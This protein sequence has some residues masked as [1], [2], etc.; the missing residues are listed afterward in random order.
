MESWPWKWGKHSARI[1]SFL[2]SLPFFL[3]GKRNDASFLRWLKVLSRNEYGRAA[4]GSALS[5]DVVIFQPEGSFYECD[6][7]H[8]LTSILSLPT[9]CQ[10]L[11]K[12]VV[13]LNGTFPE[14][15]DS[16][17]ILISSFL[18]ECR[19]VALRDRWSAEYYKAD[20][21]PDLAFSYRPQIPNSGRA[22][23]R[24]NSV[25][26]TTGA[27]FSK[28]RNMEL[29]RV[30]LD[31]CRKEDLQPL[32]L[33]KLGFHVEGLRSEIESMNGRLILRSNLSDA[34]TLVDQC[35]L[36]IGGRYHMAI[37]ALTLSI[38][39][40]L[41]RTNTHKN[42]WLSSEITG[43]ELAQTEAQIPK[44]GKRLLNQSH[45]FK[46][47]IS[48]DL[49]RMRSAIAIN[50]PH[51]RAQLR[52]D[53]TEHHEAVTL[54]DGRSLE[55]QLEL[56]TLAGAL[57]RDQKMRLHKTFRHLRMKVLL[58]KRKVVPFSIFRAGQA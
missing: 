3:G 31:F 15:R 39:S 38:P 17:A 56:S 9:L 55:E 28:K 5:S 26:I 6:D 41:V 33:T 4:Y 27:R 44:L 2:T 46:A 51:L 30:A 10:R 19:W 8:K 57:V 36:H 11:G 24:S 50:M 42:E 52:N 34:A 13:C 40:V 58:A 49:E 18:R 25:L 54:N 48:K 47:D 22:T 21:I 14:Y 37:L 16:R 35:C 1:R 32:V 20:F 43:I 7:I 53:G 12:P 29:T 45:R 23:R